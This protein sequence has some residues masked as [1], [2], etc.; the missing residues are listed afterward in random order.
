MCGKQQGISFI[1]RT[2]RQADGF[3]LHWAEIYF[4]KSHLTCQS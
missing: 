2:R 3:A 4:G 1:L